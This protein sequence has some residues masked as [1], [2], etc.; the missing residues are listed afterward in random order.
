MLLSKFCPNAIGLWT[1]FKTTTVAFLSIFC[2][3]LRL[4]VNWDKICTQRLR[5]LRNLST[6]DNLNSTCITR[7][8][9]CMCRAYH[10]TPCLNHSNNAGCRRSRAQFGEVAISTYEQIWFVWIYCTPNRD[11]YIGKTT[12]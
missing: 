8:S 7:Y 9:I 2:S 6:L 12:M 11:S 4:C 10:C 3:N 1:S 5:V